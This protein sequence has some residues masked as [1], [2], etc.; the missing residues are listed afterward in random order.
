MKLD[1]QF[2]EGIANDTDKQQVA[3]FYLDR[4]RLIGSIPLAE[5]IENEMIIYSLRKWVMSYFR[6]SILVVHRQNP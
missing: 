5:G 3:R 4:A 2:V 1:R 6:V